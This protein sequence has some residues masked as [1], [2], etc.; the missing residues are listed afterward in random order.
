MGSL[1]YKLLLAL[2]IL[3]AN[4]LG[5]FFTI[6][7]MR[8]MSRAKTVN[9]YAQSF[10][11][12]IFLGIVFL[13]L[14]P[15]LPIEEADFNKKYNSKSHTSITSCSAV[16]G[17]IFM[18]LI[19]STI[20]AIREKK[21]SLEDVEMSELPLASSMTVISPPP[22]NLY[23][24]VLFATLMSVHSLFEGLPIGYKDAKEDILSY[25]L[26]M[27]LHKFL[28]AM[29]VA[30]AGY[31]EKKVH[32]ILGCTIHSLMTPIGSLIGLT[33][34]G[35]H[36]NLMVDVALLVVMGM[37]VGTIVYIT[38]MEILTPLM[39]NPEFKGVGEFKKIGAIL[40]GFLATVAISA[41]IGTLESHQATSGTAI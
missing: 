15:E 36:N 11:A 13:M 28:E 27:L 35:E 23:K 19:D 41:V 21:K 25:G 37:S 22:D 7:A 18:L 2:G 6:T 30:S 1:G 33:L 16:F 39:E 5:G 20:K 24:F 8:C 12:G 9:T 34:T 40:G 38:F 4:G 14:N 31:K 17:I 3:F 29:T 32:A 26:P 10:T